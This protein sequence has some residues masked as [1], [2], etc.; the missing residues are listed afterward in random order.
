MSHSTQCLE[1]HFWSLVNGTVSLFL[2]NRLAHPP[3]ARW[4]KSQLSFLGAHPFP[5]WRI[6]YNNIQSQ[7][8]MGYADSRL[9]NVNEQA[10]G[11]GSCSIN[12]RCNLLFFS[13]IVDDYHQ[14]YDKTHSVASS[15]SIACLAHCIFNHFSRLRGIEPEQQLI[16][17]DPN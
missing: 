5:K 8:S 16:F 11:F 1:K 12:L 13:K 3:Q 9:K 10:P 15:T 17:V 7:L 6:C 4:I 14:Q 2:I